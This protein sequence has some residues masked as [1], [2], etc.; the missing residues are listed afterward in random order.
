VGTI[1]ALVVDE[2]PM[3]KLISVQRQFVSDR[4]AIDVPVIPL[5]VL[6]NSN[7][8]GAAAAAL[9]RH[10]LQVSGTTGSLL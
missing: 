9:A 2:L 5:A 10:L 3:A 8:L 4:A 7:A 6:Q 1:Q